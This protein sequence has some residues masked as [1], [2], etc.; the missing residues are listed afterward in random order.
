VQVYDGARAWVKDPGGVHNVPDQMAR[1]LDSSFAR[2]VIALLLAAHDGRVRPR[3]LPDVKADDGRTYH[4][5][6]FSSPTLEPT[7]L[8]IDP[9]TGLVARQNYVA[10]GP[11]QPIVE[12]RFSDY[13]AV[14]GIQIAFTAGVRQAGQLV[15]E[16]HVSEIHINAPIDPSLFKRPVS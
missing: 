8:Y 5:L 12:E 2:D 10:G 4:V 6:E 1:E 14:D 13:R 9:A 11:G 7:I 15:L 3:R 16:R